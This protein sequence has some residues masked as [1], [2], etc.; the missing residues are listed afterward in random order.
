MQCGSR[1]FRTL[2]G[3]EKLELLNKYNCV[4]LWIDVT[5]VYANALVLILDACLIKLKDPKDQGDVQ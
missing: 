2:T 5:K 4:C 1:E 3:I